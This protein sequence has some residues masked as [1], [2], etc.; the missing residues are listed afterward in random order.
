MSDGRIKI[1]RLEAP[2]GILGPNARRTASH[3]YQIF[4]ST[5]RKLVGGS[6]GPDL[7]RTKMRAL[8]IAEMKGIRSPEFEFGGENAASK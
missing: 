4:D 3:V 2:T 8:R 7:E 6:F 1:T 5:G